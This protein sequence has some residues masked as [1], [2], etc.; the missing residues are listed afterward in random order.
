MEEE[1]VLKLAKKSLSLESRSL[2][3][4]EQSNY[5]VF[6]KH[7]SRPIL[8]LFEMSKPV[9]CKCKWKNGVNLA[10]SL[11]AMFKPKSL[12]KLQSPRHLQ[13]LKEYDGGSRKLAGIIDVGH[14][15][16]AVRESE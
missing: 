15:R 3:Y 7:V 2:R 14:L 9:W 11:Q 1:E 12:A 4:P 8:Q 16:S 13:L 5:D 6:R 10:I